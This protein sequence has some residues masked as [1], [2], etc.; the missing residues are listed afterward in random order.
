MNIV[1]NAVVTILPKDYDNENRK[2]HGV[3]SYWTIYHYNLYSDTFIS[4]S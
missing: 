1:D 4:K 2:I 3:K